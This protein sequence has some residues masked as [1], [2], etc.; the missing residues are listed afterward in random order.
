MF[1]GARDPGTVAGAGRRRPAGARSTSPSTDSIAAVRG[2][3]DALDVLV[4]NAA[5]H[6][7]TW[8]AR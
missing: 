4:N 5:I 1:A 6:Y 7:D 3:I 2:E 8:S